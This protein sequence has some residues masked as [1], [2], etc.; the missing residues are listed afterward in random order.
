[1]LSGR[2]AFIASLFFFSGASGEGPLVGL[3]WNTPQELRAIEERA[4]SVRYV[5]RGIAFVEGDLRALGNF[6]VL[7][8]DDPEAGDR[9]YIADHIHWSLPEEAELVYDCLLY[10]SD[11]ATILLV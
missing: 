5:A 9:Y 3:A 10:T 7:C 4:E 2:G 11:A 1:M 8:V 6:R